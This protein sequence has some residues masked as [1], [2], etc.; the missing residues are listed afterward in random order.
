MAAV[1]VLYLD[2]KYTSALLR[3]VVSPR[4]RESVLRVIDR[5]PERDG[6]DADWHSPAD[7]QPTSSRRH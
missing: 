6:I 3:N 2:E 4:A 5:L 1:S 7:Q